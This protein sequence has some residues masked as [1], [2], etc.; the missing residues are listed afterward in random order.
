MSSQQ[1][2]TPVKTRGS[3]DR[4]KQ[5]DGDVNTPTS[6]VTPTQKVTSFYTRAPAAKPK[7]Q[8]DANQQLEQHQI[9]YEQ[10]KQKLLEGID[11]STQILSDL[12]EFSS[13]RW[14]VHYPQLESKPASPATFAIR[15]SQSTLPGQSFE[16]SAAQFDSQ[17]GSP[18]R[19]SHPSLQRCNTTQGASASVPNTPERKLPVRSNTT[20]GRYQEDEGAD[21][22][23]LKLD[24]KLGAASN[25][26][27]Q[28]VQSLEK[29]SVAQLL[30]SRMEQSARHL[31]KLKQRISDTQS[32]VLI[33]GDLNA[34]KST[35]V[36]AL[37][38]RQLMPTDQQPCTTVFCEVIDATEANND[39]EEVHMLKKGV[40]YDPKNESTFIR[41]KVS[42]IERIVEEAEEFSPE[43]API[44]K[45][46]TH[47]TRG[48]QQ[49]LLKNGVVDIALIDAPGLNRD[50]LKTT[51]LFARQEEID[52]VVFVVSA[53]NHFTL[54]AKEFLWN[55]SNDKAYVF[56]VVNKY[57]SI[58]NK[59][60]CRKLVLDQIRQ[61]SPRT[62][63]DAEDLVHFVDS[64][65]VFGQDEGEDLSSLPETRMEEV[66]M[67]VGG[68]PEE[69]KAKKEEEEDKAAVAALK[70]AD[71]L[72][73][74]ARLE[75]AL[76]DFVLLKRSKSKLLP[77]QTYLIRLLSDIAFLAKTNAQVAQVEL[78]QA[79]EKLAVA[80]PDLAKCQTKRQQLESLFEGEEDEVVT[81]IMQE[82]QRKLDIAVERIGKGKPAVD[83][84]SLPPYPGLL[85][86][87]NYAYEVRRTLLESL[88]KAVCDAEDTTRATTQSAERRIKE[89][90]ESHLPDDVAKSQRIF[91]PEAMFAKRRAAGVSG[92]G[93]RDEMF[94]VKVSDL[95][96][97]LHHLSIVTGGSSATEKGKGVGGKSL[98]AGSSESEEEMSL[99]SSLSLGLGALTL[100]GGKTFGAKTAIETIVRL[101]DLI[102]NPTA[103]RWAGP[104]FALVSTGLIVYFVYDLPNSVPRNVGRSLTSSLTSSWAP[105]PK[106]FTT[107]RELEVDPAS[108]RSSPPPP[109]SDFSTTHSARMARETRKILR[110][111]NWDL[112]ERFRVAIATRRNAV[113]AAEKKEKSA[114]DAIRFFQSTSENVCQVR[115]KVEV[116]QGWE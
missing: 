35:F 64:S 5:C 65:V 109:Q 46:Y 11:R 55:A 114:N 30:D 57:D 87:W 17:H 54:S 58:K 88:D 104:A 60:K 71:S 7:S 115:R 25:N 23:V 116:V 38:R 53:E 69:D 12:R 37:L 85:D 91:L 41:H 24:L 27:H 107:K 51:A 9:L 95:F 102:G 16:E 29:S 32:K 4:S 97:A 103:R 59:E 72:R 61:L 14:I 90:G 83:G 98:T 113:E 62:Y 81:A 79:K 75:A 13:N 100:V 67:K 96:D 63:E 66:S 39:V 15:R 34:G 19:P 43:D 110:M 73:A 108:S 1:Y 112:Q 92:L 86:V 89:M 28:L 10:S 40:A 45:C 49:S 106:T 36:N 78:D 56:I 105:Q 22:S 111:S 94:E 50:S 3:H 101:S 52:V 6:P 2:A 18:T 93:I 47:D 44:L 84:F 80:R 99:V 76:R 82:A 8:L 74:F 20:F 31:E 21:M 33:T 68:V 26:S 77:A 70:N 48:T 42:E